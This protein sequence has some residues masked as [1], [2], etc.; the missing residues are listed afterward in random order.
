MD[1]V[2]FFQPHE[3][4]SLS[5]LAERCGAELADPSLS[6]R[7]IKGVAPLS[8]ASGDEITFA[9]SR[10]ALP[11]LKKSRA[12]AVFVTASISGDVPEG[13]AALIVAAPQTGFALAA[14]ALVPDAM[15]PQSL[16]GQNGTVHSGAFVDPSARLEDG[17]TVEFGAVIGAGAEIGSGAVIGAGASV[18]SCC[19]IG[20]NC[21]IGPGVTI[22]HALIGSEVIIHPGA[23]IGQDG[24]G[25]A[26]GP[27]GL[28][29]IP[30]IGRVIIQ[31]RVEIGANTAIDRGALDDTVIGEGTKIDNLV[32]IG[33][34]VRIG[35]FCV[36]VG[37]VGV[38]G[39][40][41][42]G[43]GVM[44][45]GAAGV[46][47]HVTIGDGAQIAALSG[48]ATDV[49]PGARWGGQPAR[50]M[51]GVLRDAAEANARAF[52]KSKRRDGGQKK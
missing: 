48:V 36:L 1:S 39:S 24:F 3:G 17:V 35:R 11:D 10:K 46:N 19:R 47:G 30:Q 18:G 15:R 38:A 20:R 31:D 22:Q 42:I 29:K 43:N 8:R 27:G 34:N 41:T 16:S 14:A 50:P 40:A 23:R 25:Y 32:Q 2:R 13:V 37:Q 51:Q 6:G 4:L 5:E 7:R 28:I 52:G 44:I 49:P 12:G 26:P 45:G 9:N 21:H 33:H